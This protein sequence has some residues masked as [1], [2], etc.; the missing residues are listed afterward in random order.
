MGWEEERQKKLFAK[1]RRNMVKYLK[2]QG[3]Y[4]ISD[5]K[6]MYYNEIR[7][8][9]EKE[10]KEVSK[11][12]WSQKERNFLPEK[13]KRLTVKRQKM[14]EET[15][16]EDLKGYLDIVLREEGDGSSKNYKVLSEM[17]EDFDRQD[18]MDLY[19]LFKERYSASRPEGY[20]LMLWGCLHTLF[21][22]CRKM[23]IWKYQH[24]YNL[25]IITKYLV[26]ISK[27][28]AFWS[29]N[30]DILKITILTTNTPY[31][32]RKIRRIRACTQLN[33]SYPEDQYAVLEISLDE[34]SP[35]SKND[36]PLLD[37]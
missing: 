27:R 5:F 24:D 28:R 13:S 3:N 19:R 1:A 31:P 23:K 26:N 11:R 25:I 16:K 2:N 20:D 4:K 36:M 22:L 12:N 35:K 34:V 30:E 37:K 6:G 18:V 14:E 32:S 8:I 15:E 7:P 21:E 10:M 29:L 9:F 17:L 33:T